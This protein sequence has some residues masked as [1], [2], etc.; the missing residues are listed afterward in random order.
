MIYLLTA[1]FGA[2][3][4]QANLT[5]QDLTAHFFTLSNK[6]LFHSDASTFR[7]KKTIE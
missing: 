6:V 5:F 3:F 1:N 2:M 4:Y 7:L